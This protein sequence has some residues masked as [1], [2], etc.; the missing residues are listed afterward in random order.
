MSIVPAHLFP[1]HLN[2]ALG[3]A[4]AELRR[5]VL[6]FAE[7]GPV[8]PRDRSRRRD[9]LD[10]VRNF[11][12]LTSIHKTFQGL[13]ASSPAAARSRRPLILPAAVLPTLPLLEAAIADLLPRSPDQPWDA[14]EFRVPWMLSCRL[15]AVRREIGPAAPPSGFPLPSSPPPT[16]DPPAPPAPPSA[17]PCVPSEP[18]SADAPATRL[19]DPTSLAPQTSHDRSTEAD[20]SCIGPI[21]P[22][23]PISSNTDSPSPSDPLLARHFAI[24]NSVGSTASSRP[25]ASSPFRSVPRP[26]LS[27]IP[28]VRSLLLICVHLCAL[29]VETPSFLFHLKTLL[30]LL[31]CLTTLRPTPGAHPLPP[32]HRAR[33]P[34][35]P[36]PIPLAF[37]PRLPRLAACALAL[38]P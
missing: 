21:R 25:R 27:R 24:R 26:R 36:S 19:S 16:P 12:R 17:P 23:G 6:R 1:S 34:H 35:L 15:I 31:R 9:L 7:A 18:P 10:L 37:A 33:V 28:A 11:L 20:P 38:P 30:A 8:S 2:A 3:N 4:E 22:I 13:D 29:V 32:F 5:A 14:P